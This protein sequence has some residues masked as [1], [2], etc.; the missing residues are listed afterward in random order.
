MDNYENTNELFNLRV[1]KYSH[2]DKNT[3]FK[4]WTEILCWISKGDFEIPNKMSD[5]YIKIYH[6]CAMFKFSKL[7]DLNNSKWISAVDVLQCIKLCHL[8]NLQVF[9]DAHEGIILF[10]FLVWGKTCLRYNEHCLKICRTNNFV[11]SGRLHKVNNHCT[12]WSI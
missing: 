9:Q 11:F 3:S 10:Q 7:L 4:V 2:L 6:F 8:D 1:C 12:F 5:P